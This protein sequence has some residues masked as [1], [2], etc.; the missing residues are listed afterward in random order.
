[1]GFAFEPVGAGPDTGDRSDHRQFVVRRV[2]AHAQ[3]TVVLVGAQMDHSGETMRRAFS[4]WAV[5]PGEASRTEAQF[6]AAAETFGG[7]VG[8]FPL[9]AAMAQVIDA[10][11]IDQLLETEVVAQRK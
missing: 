11:Q 6:H 8:R 9:V 5:F 10:A 2:A 4:A 7:N 3:Q 1:E